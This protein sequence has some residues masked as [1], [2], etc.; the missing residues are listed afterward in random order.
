MSGSECVKDTVRVMV[1]CVTRR[2]SR[3]RRRRRRRRRDTGTDRG[4]QPSHTPGTN[5]IRPDVHPLPRS[6]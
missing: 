5:R 6:Q 3:R 1:D 4:S 2:R